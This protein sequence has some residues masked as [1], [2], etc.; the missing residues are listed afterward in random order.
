[1]TTRL[2]KFSMDSHRTSALRSGDRTKEE[3]CTAVDPSALGSRF[4]LI[5]WLAQPFDRSEPPRKSLP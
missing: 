3:S 1:M 2:G 4:T 5:R